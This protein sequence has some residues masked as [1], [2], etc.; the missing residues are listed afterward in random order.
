MADQPGPSSPPSFHSSSRVELDHSITVLG[1]PSPSPDEDQA[2]EIREKLST[3]G[4]RLATT[5]VELLEARNTCK[6]PD[7]VNSYVKELATFRE[8]KRLF[9]CCDGTWKNASGTIAPLTN[10]AKL[11][12]CVDRIGNDELGPTSELHDGSEPST[13]FGLVRQLVYYSSG[14]G[15]QSSLA[16]DSGF[17]GATGH[18][19][20]LVHFQPKA[21][22]AD[23]SCGKGV[24]ANILSAYCFICNNYNFSSA[25]DDIIL[26]GFSRGAFTVRCLAA[27]IDKVGLLRRKGLP[28]LRLL[29]DHWLRQ[30]TDQ[31]NIMAEALNPLRYTGVR[32]KVLAE[33]DPVSAMGLPF[34]FRTR[35]FSF[36]DDKVPDVVENAFVAIALNEKRP[37]FKPLLWKKAVRETTVKQC[38]F[39]GSHSDIGGGN[40]DSG[41]ST[42][43]LLWMISQITAACDTQFDSTTLL[44]FLTPLQSS[45]LG[46]ERAVGPGTNRKLYLKNLSSTEGTPNH[47]TS[48]QG[49]VYLTYMKDT[50]PSLSLVCGWY[51]SIYL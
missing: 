10:V 29:F 6:P 13:R 36:I 37:S 41:L 1:N 49:A 4:E 31:L 2:R 22:T 50:L 15:T 42:V 51:R 21:I 18:G 19:M 34:G 14:V 7:T 27:F 5:I 33:W 20:S 11:A 23:L 35:K 43:S 30:K 39:I 44:Q 16:M 47:T 40:A 3:Y 32:I 46:H 26:V 38:G 17:S 25:M 28:F 45:L 12:R 24:T 8:K 48:C 9:V